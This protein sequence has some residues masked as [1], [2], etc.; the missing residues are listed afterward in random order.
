[1]ISFSFFHYMSEL[2][3][4]V[5][6]NFVLL[7]YLLSANQ[8]VL[9]YEHR[10]GIITISCCPARSMLKSVHLELPQFEVQK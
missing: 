3:L 10:A 2:N 8:T 1:M 7:M 9:Q 5:C 6:I 4:Y